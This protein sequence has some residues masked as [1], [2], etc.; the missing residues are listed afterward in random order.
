MLPVLRRE[1]EVVPPTLPYCVHSRAETSPT[2]SP[3]PSAPLPSPRKS[4]P[5]TPT[6]AAHR[7]THLGHLTPPLP[8]QGAAS[9]VPRQARGVGTAKRLVV[10][11][12]SGL[13]KSQVKVR[14][15]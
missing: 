13:Q 12:P 14:G 9:G 8:Q 6:P 4:L 5:S 2:P 11:A 1:G 7:I 15:P 3:P 10:S